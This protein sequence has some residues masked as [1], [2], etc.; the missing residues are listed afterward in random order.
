MTILFG[1]GKWNNGN[2]SNV[3]GQPKLG[4]NAQKIALQDYAFL[5]N[6]RT[7]PITNDSLNLLLAKELA[8]K[9][10]PHVVSEENFRASSKKHTF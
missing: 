1:S 8:N 9:I 3:S 6:V 5:E 4:P 2:H 10:C 7:S